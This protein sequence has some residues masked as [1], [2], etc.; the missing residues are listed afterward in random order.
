MLKAR[1]C[2]VLALLI[3]GVSFVAQA[4]DDQ[5]LTQPTVDAAVSQILQQTADRRQAQATQIAATQTIQA[6]LQS[7]I[8]ATAQAWRHPRRLRRGK[9]H[10][11]HRRP[12]LICWR[13]RQ[14]HR[15]FSRRTVNTSL[16]WRGNATFCIYA[17]GS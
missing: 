5:P 11:W 8:T 10:S 12:S 16:I 17:G 4:Q 6:A 15:L 9:S 1:F 14:E 7:A 2:L 3:S 13:A